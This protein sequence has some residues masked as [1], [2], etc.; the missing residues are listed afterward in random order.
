MGFG[1]SGLDEALA[2]TEIQN[3]HSLL[4]ATTQ[5]RYPKPQ[6]LLLIAG[7]VSG[8][9][10][11]ARLAC[12]VGRRHPDWTLWA[13][14]GPHLRAA[15]LKMLGDSSGYGVI[16]FASALSILPRVLRLRRR[17]LRFLR[18]HRIDAA[19][20]CDWGAFNG[21]LL[22]YLEERGI[23]VLYYFPPRSWQKTGDG[24][25]GIAPFVSRV[26]TPFEWSAK[27]LNEAGCGAEWIGHPLLETVRPLPPD[28]PK[29]A[30]LRR[31]LDVPDGAKLIVLMPGSR[32]LELKYIA[33][34]LA[35]AARLLH[36]KQEKPTAREVL[37]FVVAVPRGAAQRA[38]RYFPARIKIVEGRAT[39]GLMACDDAVVKSGTSTLEAAVACA[40]Q[41]VVYDGPKLMRAQYRLTGM[42]RKVPLVAMPNII[43]EREAVPE[44]L[45]DDCRAETIARELSQLLSDNDKR[46]RI[47][48][49]YSAVRR[50][51]GEDLPFSATG[52][53]AQ[54]LD[55]MLCG[56]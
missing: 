16:G 45:G 33:P 7:D 51:L 26:A 55:E 50:A 53:T 11:L 3:E 21:R 43:L 56:N 47:S 40:P 4:T 19:V 22:P 12:E 44:L 30:Q 42:R 49:D 10:N 8:D 23:P 31:E 24:G 36:A 9:I 48:N 14:G 6:T 32:D 28:S 18:S 2:A 27:R 13:V 15:G 52:R 34:H 37:H 38:R 25:L 46:A 54:M 5:T 1:V 35:Q 17:V 41:V 39:D 20:L 29:R